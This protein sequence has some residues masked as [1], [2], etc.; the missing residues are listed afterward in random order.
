MWPGKVSQLP[1]GAGGGAG[2]GLQHNVVFCFCFG[3]DQT[4][5]K[6]KGHRRKTENNFKKW[7]SFYK[8]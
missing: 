6:E 3:L 1:G 8:N 7:L 4:I 5:L 2:K